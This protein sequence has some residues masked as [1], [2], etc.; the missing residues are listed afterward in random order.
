MRPPPGDRS[1]T[2]ARV[3]VRPIPEAT[4][5]RLPVYLRVLGDLATQQIQT[6]SSEQLAEAAGVNPPKVRK[7]LSYLG[8]YGT[9]GVGYDVEYLVYQISRELG[10]TQDWPVAIVGMG[11]LGQALAGY[12]GFPERG[13]KIDALFDRD[14][15]VVGHKTEGFGIEHI[16]DLERSLKEKD[17]SIAIIATPAVAAQETAERLVAAGVRSILNFAPTVLT[18]PDKIHLRQVDLSVELQ[19]LAFYEQRAAVRRKASPK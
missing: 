5:A 18:V 12:K 17:I 3:R 6:V 15:K 14:E 10:L 19:I 13:F 7:D 8:S 11:N 4:V 2:G 9:R 1:R 16:D